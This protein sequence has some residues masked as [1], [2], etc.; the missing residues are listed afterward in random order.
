MCTNS[1]FGALHLWFYGF[2]YFYQDYRDFVP[3]IYN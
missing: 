3:F 1:Y 2:N